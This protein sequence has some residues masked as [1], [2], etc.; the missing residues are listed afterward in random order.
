MRLNTNPTLAH[1]T[2]TIFHWLALGLAIFL[3]LSIQSVCTIS[4]SGFE[5]VMGDLAQHVGDCRFLL[6]HT[7]YSRPPVKLSLFLVQWDAKTSAG[8]ADENV[9]PPPSVFH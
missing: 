1:P 6:I 5:A 8:W 3:R 7:L 2:Q 9:F 4:C